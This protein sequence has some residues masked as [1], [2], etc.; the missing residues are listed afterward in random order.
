MPRADPE[1][2]ATFRTLAVR[3]GGKALYVASQSGP[4]RE[5]IGNTAQALLNESFG[6]IEHYEVRG[7]GVAVTWLLNQPVSS[8]G[9]LELEAQLEGLTYAGQTA[10]GFHFA[11]TTGTARVRVGNTTV[12][13]AHG[14]KWAAPARAEENHLFVSVPAAI[15]AEAHYLLAIDPV[16]GAEFGMDLPILGPAF[17]FQ[18]FPAVA[19]NGSDYLVVWQSMRSNDT[20]AIYGTRLR[21][22][23][24]VADPDGIAIGLKGRGNTMPAVSSD[25]SNYLVVW[26][27]AR[28]GA[29]DIYGA[30]VSSDG[31]VLDAFEIRIHQSVSN[32]VHPA[33]AF[34]GDNYL[35]VWEK[36]AGVS[37]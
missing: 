35:V 16:I 3:L 7:E 14:R 29:S 18:W 33:V 2:A 24:T 36:W 21:S 27:E 8:R 4:Q 13:D 32:K 17:G 37:G 28:T 23:G 12:V 34:N 26:E 20:G 22:D 1:P 9:S 15:L 6:L 5:A 25:G 10:E 30:W 31:L 19:S 11:D